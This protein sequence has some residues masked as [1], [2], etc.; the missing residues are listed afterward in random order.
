MNSWNTK[1]FHFVVIIKLQRCVN[2]VL[3]FIFVY[4][5]LNMSWNEEI[6]RIICKKVMPVSTVVKKIKN[7]LNAEILKLLF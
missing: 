6:F 3:L 2:L 5:L 7:E 4:N 1:A